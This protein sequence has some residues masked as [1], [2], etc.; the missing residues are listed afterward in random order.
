MDR[1]G[2]TPPPPYSVFE[3]AAGTELEFGVFPGLSSP[4]LISA[5]SRNKPK[6]LTGLPGPG[7]P[8]ATRNRFGDLDWD[9]RGLER[10]WAT[11]VKRVHLTTN[12][13]TALSLTPHRGLLGPWKVS[14]RG[15]EATWQ[16]AA[17][18]LGAFRPRPPRGKLLPRAFQLA[19]R[20]LRGASGYPRALFQTSKTRGW[21]GG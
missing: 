12:P 7:K 8:R 16:R 15:K 17:H 10:H 19:G 13:Q 14:E 1:G 9:R 11:A 18:K 21:G 2:L 20:E 3:A 5:T 4:N 6:S